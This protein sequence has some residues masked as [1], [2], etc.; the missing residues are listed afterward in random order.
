MVL[1][2]ETGDYY[3]DNQL[4]LIAEEGVPKARIKSLV[5]KYQGEIVG[6]IELADDYEIGFPQAETLEELNSIA[7][8]LKSNKYVHDVMIDYMYEIWVAENPDGKTGV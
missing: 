6:H 4:L 3:A 7:G 5:E 2:A 8:E 1:D